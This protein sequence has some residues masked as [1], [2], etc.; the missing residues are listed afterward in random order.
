MWQTSSN[1]RGLQNK[2]LSRRNFLKPKRARTRIKSN[3]MTLSMTTLFR[4]K[5]LQA[6]QLS[7][8]PTVKRWCVGSK[9]SSRLHVRMFCRQLPSGAD[10]SQ[11][12]RKT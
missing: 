6:T 12:L 9:E 7:T 10:N 5:E 11:R 1:T 3:Y 4:C 8:P 2:Y